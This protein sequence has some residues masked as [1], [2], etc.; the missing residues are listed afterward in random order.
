MH[1]TLSLTGHGFH[2]MG[3]RHSSAPALPGYRDPL[4]RAEA[5]MLD[6]VLLGPALGSPGLLLSGGTDAVQLDPMPLLG[7][8]VPHSQAI[9][10]GASVF[11]SHT[12][13]FHTARAFAVLDNLSAGRTA[14]CVDTRQ[15]DYAAADFAHT[16]LPAAARYARAREYIG[17]VQRLWDSWEDDAIIA[18]KASGIFAH[19]TKVH[20]IDHAGE[21]FTVRGPLTAIRPRQGRPVIVQWDMSS[22]GLALAAATADVFLA[23]CQTLA[24]AQAFG[25]RLRSATAA[26]GRNPAALRILLN[27]MPIFGPTVGAA[28]D[29]A[30]SLDAAVT[31]ALAEA[32]LAEAGAGATLPAVLETRSGLRFIGTAMALAEQMTTWVAAGACDGW[33]LRPAVLPDD[34]DLLLGELAPALQR[35]GQLRQSYADATLRAHLGLGRPANPNAA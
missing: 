34:L 5:A 31:P 9:G 18:D 7:S 26:E 28:E 25:A 32:L 22:E 20:R 12:E 1:L 23:S 2:P 15:M 6:A 16:P 10:L 29:R 19:G 27:V 35:A 33:N 17:V 13:P 21:Y 11:M 24:E 3:W 4:R 30:A 14:W 8:L